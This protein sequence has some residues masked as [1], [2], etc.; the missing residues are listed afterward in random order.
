MGIVWFIVQVILVALATFYFWNNYG[1]WRKQHPIVS[2]ATYVA[3]LISFLALL[4]LPMDIA[5]LDQLNERNLTS[6]IESSSTSIPLEICEAPHNFVPDSFLYST[7]R[8][9]YWSSFLL[10]WL[11]LPIMQ[12]YSNAGDFTATGKLKSALYNNAIYYGIYGCLFI[13]LL[14]YALSK[15]V[16]MNFASNT[17][18]LFLLVV[19]LGY[20]LVEVP[21]Q[22]WQMGNKGYRLQKTYFDIEKLSTDK[23]DAEETIHELYNEC[24]EV[25]NLLKN[26]RGTA[27]EKLHLIMS[28]FPTDKF[29]SSARSVPTYAASSSIRNA[30][31]H[32][33]SQ[34]AYLIRLNK[35][36]I[37][38][39]Q[40]HHRTQSQ[41]YTLI[42]KA[43]YLEDVEIAETSGKLPDWP[44]TSVFARQ[45]PIPVRFAW[46]VTLKR[47]LIQATAVVCA[48]MTLLIMWSECTFFILSLAARFLHSMALG[49]HYKYLQWIAI[50]LLL[51]LGLCSYYTIFHLR[52]YRY[53]RLDVNHMTDANS[54]IFSAML[55]CR[56]TP[57]LCL[58]FLGMIHLDSHITANTNFGV[59][60]Q[61]TKL[62][63]HLDVIPLVARG[64]NIYLPIIIVILCLSTWFRLGTRFLHSLG[65]DQFINDDEMTAELVQS[66]RSIV[67]LERG[68]ITR[69]RDR[70][71]RRETWASK[72]NNVMK[73]QNNGS[74][75]NDRL[76]ILEQQEDPLLVDGNESRGPDR[77]YST[78]DESQTEDLELRNSAFLI[79]TSPTSL[80]SSERYSRTDGTLAFYPTLAYN[81][82]RNYVQPTRWQWYSR[83]DENLILGALP[84][85]SMIAE[86]KAENVGGVVC[87]TEEFETRA[88][89][90]G[91]GAEQWQEADIKFCHVPMQD[92]VGTTSRQNL[93]N[94]VKFIDNLAEQGRTVYVHCKAGRTRSATV[95]VCYLMHKY[96]YTPEQ[97]MNAVV[98]ARPQ[99]LLRTAHWNSVNDYRVFLDSEGK[100]QAAA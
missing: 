76:P 100:N 89:Y 31:V 78:V 57:P 49:Y 67:G 19:L 61:F 71:Q 77:F 43:F 55:L 36:V 81:L 42:Q 6:R 27:R 80:L 75:Y 1:N 73:N 93:H 50:I 99:A 44:E 51:Y 97:A 63:G 56:L 48:S 53:Y 23:N 3:W 60:T 45:I 12:S 26:T 25:L 98:R 65:V 52:I 24:K 58:N 91:M 85:K 35:R 47:P 83:V 72:L 4:L 18:G 95:A 9:V 8:F 7:W 17:W 5:I 46:H 20:G 69:Q 84:F 74:Q 39:I 82:L 96:N 15:G 34:E 22:L 30:D 79:D 92:F 28:R 41:W 32:A 40:N 29:S 14:F 54:L 62:M 13:F 66:G 87:C 11:V 86:L 68:K 16:S 38:A 59:E 21:R 33:V 64:I 90:N 94:A 88:A 10:T 37:E 2:L 70:E